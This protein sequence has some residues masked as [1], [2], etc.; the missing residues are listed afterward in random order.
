MSTSVAFHRTLRFRIGKLI[1]RAL[2]AVGLRSLDSQYTFS[3]LLILLLT[4]TLGG[5]GWYALDSQWQ[6]FDQA[7]RSLLTEVESQLDAIDGDQ[8]QRVLDTVNAHQA[9]VLELQRENTE[10]VQFWLL[11]VVVSLLGLNVFGRVFGL[12]VLMR[13]IANLRDHLRLL[14]GHDFSTPIEV[15]NPNNEV[16]QNYKAYNDIVLEIGQ[17]VHKVTLTSGRINTAADQVVTTLNDTDRGVREQ[18][19]SI[20]QVATAI[21]EM[22]ATVQEVA[23][24][25]TS[26]A[27][28]AEQASSSAHDGQRLMAHTVDSIDDVA[29]QVESASQVIGTLADDS[30]E[31]SQILVVITNIAE[32]TNLLA[33]NAAI[34]AARAGE[35]GRG[36][37][38]VA[39][40]VRTLAQRTQESIESIRAI[41]ERLEGGAESAVKAMDQSR[42]AAEKTAQDAH[43]TRESLEQIV[44]A[45]GV[46][47][48]MNTQIATAAEEQSQVAQDMDHNI[49][50]ISLQSRRTADYAKQTVDATDQISGHIQKLMEELG[51]FKTNVQGVDLGAAK[52]A[53]LSWKVRL[54]SYLD[55]KA[56][57]TLKEAVSHRDCAFGKWY[58]SEGLDRYSAIPE[59]KQIEKPHEELH[60]LVKRAIELKEQGDFAGAE[61]LYDQVS[62]IS[63][64]IVERLNTIEDRIEE[65]A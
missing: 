46:I 47:L 20:E 30:R 13:Q 53:H 60:A 14:G 34:E 25:A 9:Q 2:S 62:S 32:Q 59:M 51:R 55:G 22:A 28:A 17:L 48:D 5:L 58:Y 65:R 36:F 10:N 21:N 33:L 41:V 63:A 16:G 50:D 15:D 8:A 37:A 56:T 29:R 38:V 64:R 39:D 42:D 12:T 52:S 24:H 61:S 3:Y 6:A 49:S 18:Q 7:Q 31:V 54:R 35:Q 19:A 27:S 57:L 26:A 4:L 43:Q 1:E 45:V 23:Q 40:E 11:I 44:A